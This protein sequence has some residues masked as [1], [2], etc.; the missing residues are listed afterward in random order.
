MQCPAPLKKIIDQCL[1]EGHV[2]IAQARTA[3]LRRW[4]LRAKTIADEGGDVEDDD[5]FP[6]HC[7]KVLA[8]K[9]MRLFGEM[10]EHAKYADKR[11]V[12]HMKEGFHLMGP[13]PETGALPT[14][15]TVG[16]LTLEEVRYVCLLT[17]V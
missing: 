16:S 2:A 17:F 1:K 8:G 12:K 5:I 10:L 13:L 11:L 7:R 9:S 4:T 15:V 6:E 3:A 14:R